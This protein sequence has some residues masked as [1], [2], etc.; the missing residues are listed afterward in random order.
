MVQENL[1]IIEVLKYNEMSALTEN[2]TIQ[3]FINYHLLTLC[4]KL[5]FKVVRSWVHFKVKLL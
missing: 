1:Y 3:S 4:V 5:A 2:Y